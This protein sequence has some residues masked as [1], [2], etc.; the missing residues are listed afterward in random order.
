MDGALPSATRR[1]TPGDPELLV[2]TDHR[3]QREGGF[4]RITT[5]GHDRTLRRS[6]KHCS[7][8]RLTDRTVL[9]GMERQPCRKF[10]MDVCVAL[11]QQVAWR[12]EQGHQ[13][14]H[15]HSQ[16]ARPAVFHHHGQR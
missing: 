8:D 6:R 5:D 2:R 1:R 16:K 4:G 3:L 14:Q 10:I 12:H 13:A 15:Q 7:H 9:I 11:V